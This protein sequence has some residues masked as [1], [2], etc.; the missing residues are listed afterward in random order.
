MN[1]AVVLGL[2]FILVVGSASVGDH[3][4]SPSEGLT[5]GEAE[6]KHQQDNDQYMVTSQAEAGPVGYIRHRT[7]NK[8]LY[9]LPIRGMAL[10]LLCI[11]A[12]ITTTVFNSYLQPD[13]ATLDTLNMCQVVSTYTFMVLR[14][15]GEH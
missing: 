12:L 1:V 15:M 8:A 10:H 14:S 4:K 6:T 2:C 5:A 7:S 13:L 11:V 9:P 3:E